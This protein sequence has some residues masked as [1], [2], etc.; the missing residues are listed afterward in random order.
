MLVPVVMYIGI[1]ILL[2][3]WVS[4]SLES[5]SHPKLISFKDSATYNQGLCGRQVEIVNLANGKSVKVTVA[6]ACPTCDNEQSIDL[7]VA[8]F[9]QLADLGVGTFAIKSRFA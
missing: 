1:V 2:P 7:S 6:D 4:I 5:I 3:P 8:A 9:E